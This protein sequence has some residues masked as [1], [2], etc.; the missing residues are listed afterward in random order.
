MLQTLINSNTSHKG[1]VIIARN[2]KKRGQLFRTPHSFLNEAKAAGCPSWGHPVPSC[3]VQKMRGSVWVKDSGVLFF[4]I[5]SSL[6]GILHHHHHGLHTHT[7]PA[8]LHTGRHIHTH[9]HHTERAP[10][11]TQLPTNL[12]CWLFPKRSLAF[13]A[14][15]SWALG[16]PNLGYQLLFYFHFHT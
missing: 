14:L 1:C 13:S 15:R 4:Q 11:P 6:A 5:H 7:H 12:P 8:S 9:T 3:A 2:L 10:A 16:V